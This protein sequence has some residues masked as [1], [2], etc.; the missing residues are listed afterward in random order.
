MNL[1]AVLPELNIWAILVAMLVHTVIGLAWFQKGIFG[2][3]WSA[4]TGASLNPSTKWIP[5]GLIGH[6]IMVF[7]LAIII[8]LANATTLLEGAL[9][10]AIACI[11][12]MATLEA[13]ELIWEKIPF[14][15]YLIRIG[16]QLI[17][18]M[19]SGAILAVWR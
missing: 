2:N 4:L 17:G 14:K 19:V 5:A 13:G 10:G 8:R 9:I 7:V 16:N 3:A 1:Q 12:F 18:M 6:L 15:L 11:G